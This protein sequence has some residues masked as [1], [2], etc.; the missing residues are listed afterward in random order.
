VVPTG[1]EPPLE[2]SIVAR[3]QGYDLFEVAGW[4]PRVSVVPNFRVVPSETGALRTVLP[5]SFDPAAIAVVERDPGIE[6]TPEAQ[7]GTATYRESSPESVQIDVRATAPSIVVVRTVYDDGWHA[8]VDGGPAE[9]IPTDGFLQGVAVPAGDHEVRLTYRDASVTSGI[10][11]G[12][13]A[14][15]TL[16]LAGLVALALER[17]RGR[18]VR[19]TPP[20]ADEARPR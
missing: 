5:P 12:V 9:V 8:T 2:G 14:W 18:A 1:I 6:P 20:P 3:A 19:P 16:A 10:R 17:R 15:G 13:V 11:A 4:Q 7:P